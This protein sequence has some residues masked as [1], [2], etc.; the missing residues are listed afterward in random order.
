VRDQRAPAG[1][2]EAIPFRCL[3]HDGGYL[4]LQVL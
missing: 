4:L 3:E 2:R 1:Q